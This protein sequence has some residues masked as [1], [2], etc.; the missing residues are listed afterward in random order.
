MYLTLPATHYAANW[1]VE[2]EMYD[3]DAVTDVAV[4]Y[5]RT[6]NELNHSELKPAARNAM[7]SQCEA[8]MLEL[9]KFFHACI[10]KYVSLI[11]PRFPF[12]E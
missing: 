4:R 6:R 7:Q 3:I 8:L 10:F 5:I 12:E 1:S 11:Q 2:H 9:V